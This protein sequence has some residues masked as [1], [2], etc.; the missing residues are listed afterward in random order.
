MLSCPSVTREKNVSLYYIREAQ[1]RPLMIGHTYTESITVE[2][3]N[4]GE[5]SGCA[6]FSFVVAL[7]FYPKIKSSCGSRT[8]VYSAVLA[9]KPVSQHCGRGG[10]VTKTGFIGT[11]IK[12]RPMMPRQTP[13][14]LRLQSRSPRKQLRPQQ[15]NLI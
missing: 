7:I 11:M 10:V 9:V 13:R 5:G 12:P 3:K 1:T 15:L 14:P 6:W 2:R 4:R 8:V